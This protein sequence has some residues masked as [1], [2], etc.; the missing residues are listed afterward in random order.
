MKTKG[1]LI[2]A[3]LLLAL[4][5]AANYAEGTGFFEPDTSDRVMGVATGLVLVVFANFMPKN[6]GP[7]SESRCATSKGQNMR[8]FAAWT[9]VLA[10]IAHS[11]VW[12]TFS[13]PQAHIWGKVVVAAGMVLVVGAVLVAASRGNHA[14]NES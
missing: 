7:L 1:A 6:L 12:L 14:S 8:R 3:G 10:G 5:F 2:T 9:F 11:L 13:I 4:A